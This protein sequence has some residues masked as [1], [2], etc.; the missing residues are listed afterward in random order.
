MFGGTNEIFE[1]ARPYL[2]SF[3]NDIIHG[4]PLGCGPAMKAINN[5]IYDVNI[6]ALCGVL[7][8]AIGAGLDPDEVAR[9]ITTG[10]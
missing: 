6:V 3:G 7:P 4:E 8:L 1:A 9:L 10:S 2:E 5:I